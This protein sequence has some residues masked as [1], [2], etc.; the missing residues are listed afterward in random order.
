MICQSQLLLTP[1]FHF[2]QSAM[3]GN[4]GPTLRLRSFTFMFEMNVV[5]A[6]CVRIA[7]QVYSGS[8][9]SQLGSKSHPVAVSPVQQLDVSPATQSWLETFRRGGAV[10]HLTPV[11]PESNGRSGFILSAI[12]VTASQFSKTSVLFLLPAQ[13][14]TLKPHELNIWRLNI[15]EQHHHGV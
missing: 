3:Q 14:C 11:Y 12:D 5:F 6:T 7:L 1:F 4:T 9:W 10:F 15:C 8:S 13:L 2:S